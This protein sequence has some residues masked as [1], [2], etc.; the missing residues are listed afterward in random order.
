MLAIPNLLLP[1]AKNFTLLI[2]YSVAFAIGEGMYTTPMYC[3]MNKSYAG[4]GFGWF[5]FVHLIP[6]YAG[7]TLAG[8]IVFHALFV[9]LF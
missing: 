6:F 2:L 1:F 9:H 8:K 5:V 4:L 7:P 3:I